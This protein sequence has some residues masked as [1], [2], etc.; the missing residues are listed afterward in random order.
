M[1]NPAARKWEMIC[2]PTHTSNDRSSSSQNRAVL[3]TDGS[4]TPHYKCDSS[5][6]STWSDSTKTT[7]IAPN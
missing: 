5:T 1:P 4:I 2:N 6:S 3:N 7:L